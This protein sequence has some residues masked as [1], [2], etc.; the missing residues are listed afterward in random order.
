VALLP[1]RIGAWLL[2]GFGSLALLLA[3]VGIYGVVSYTVSQRTREIGIRAALGAG[4]GA[5]IGHVI[6]GTL[7]VVGVGVA[8]GV[9]L[10]VLAGHAARAFLYGVAPADPAVLLGTPLVLAVVAAVASWVP[11]RR[12]AAVDPMV[13]LRAE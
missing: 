8:V 9:V 12:A 3:A 4:R 7:R 11:A 6:G 13:A 10:A 2:G 1:A 5:L